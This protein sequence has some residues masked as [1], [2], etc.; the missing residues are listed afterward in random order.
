MLTLEER[1]KALKRFAKLPR[2]AGARA[3]LKPSERGFDLAFKNL[4]ARLKRTPERSRVQ[5]RLAAP[6]GGIDWTIS[7]ADGTATVSRGAVEKPDLRIV[8]PEDDG[9]AIAQGKVSPVEV[10][11]MGRMRIGGDCALAKRLYKRLAGKGDTEVFLTDRVP[12]LVGR[13]GV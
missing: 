13:G 3:S 12:G 6:Q 4:A 5:V 1:R 8:L 9:W 10:Y 7:M 11:L 2:L